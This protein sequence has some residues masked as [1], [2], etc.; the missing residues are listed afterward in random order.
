MLCCTERA[1]RVNANSWVSLQKPSYAPA[2]LSEEHQQWHWVS[3]MSQDLHCMFFKNCPYK[4][5]HPTHS[6]VKYQKIQICTMTYKK[7]IKEGS[8]TC[9]NAPLKALSSL[10]TIVFNFTQYLWTAIIL[11]QTVPLKVI[12]LTRSFDFFIKF[13]LQSPKKHRQMLSSNKSCGAYETYYKMISCKH[14]S[15]FYKTML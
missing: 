12:S 9:T 2:S 1:A 3:E 14:T 8:V 15:Q 10:F 5:K 7:S 6:S 13:I 11:L 4:I